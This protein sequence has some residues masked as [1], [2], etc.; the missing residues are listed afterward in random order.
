MLLPTWVTDTFNTSFVIHIH[1]SN[2]TFSVYD[3]S[4]LIWK[5]AQCDLYRMLHVLLVSCHVY[6]QFGSF[7]PAYIV[8]T[9]VTQCNTEYLKLP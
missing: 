5:V 6:Y 9:F 8:L 2:S 4:D 1:S 3:F 7:T